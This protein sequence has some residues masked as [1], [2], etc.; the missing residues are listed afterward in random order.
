MAQK[1]DLFKVWWH[2]TGGIDFENK[3]ALSKISGICR[4]KINTEWKRQ[5]NNLLNK[6]GLPNGKKQDVEILKFILNILECWH[7]DTCIY[8][9]SDGVF[10]KGYRNV[11]RTCRCAELHAEAL[12]TPSYY[13]KLYW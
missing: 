2:I 3:K 13:A 8:C 7:V 4:C 11:P 12:K 10:L 6:T 5:V 1:L 9:S